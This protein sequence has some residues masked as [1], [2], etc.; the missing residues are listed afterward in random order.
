MWMWEMA[1]LIPR[2]CGMTNLKHFF[3]KTLA[4]SLKQ[5]RRRAKK[6]AK[7]LQ[8]GGNARKTG[9]VPFKHRPEQAGGPVRA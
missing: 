9:P 5:I 6:S 8:V 1:R 2:A 7:I 3:L 4:L